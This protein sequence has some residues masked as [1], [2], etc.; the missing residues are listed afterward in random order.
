MRQG[1]LWLL[2]S[3]AFLLVSGCVG[4]K[5]VSTATLLDEMTDLREMAEFPSPAYTCR[6]FS[7]YD[8]ASESPEQAD[9][10]FANRDAGQF[11]RT[12]QHDGRDEYVMMDADGPGA[13]VRIW[14]ANPKGTLRVYLD[15]SETPVLEEPMADLLDG[16]VAGV[17][18]PIAGE[19]SRGHNC[20]LP[21]PYAKHCK[22]TC[23][24]EAFYYHI[25]Y[26]TYPRWTKLTSFKREDLT[27]L[28]P[29]IEQIAE[30][31]AAPR[32]SDVEPIPWIADRSV[33]A[34]EFVWPAELNGGPG[35][36]IGL[37]AKVDGSDVTQALRDVVLIIESDGER[38]VVCPLGDFCGAAPGVNA[39]ASLPLGV[40]PEGE[41][42]S[43]WVMP[44][45]KSARVGLHNLGSQT[46]HVKLG[47]ATSEY[48]WTRRSMHFHTQWWVARDVSTR[49][50]QDWNYVQ[51]AGK[52]VFAGAAFA[53]TNPVKTWWGE[54]DEKIYVDGE[55]FPSHFG[56][57]T[58]DYYGYAWCYNVPFTHA[59]HAQ[60]RCDGP[61]NYGHTAVNRWHIIDRIPFKR[62]FRFDMELWHW[63]ECRLPAMSVVTY[64]YARP[65]ASSNR[66][67]IDPADLP[68]PVV[69]PY[70]APR[71]DG[72][73][74]GEELRIVAKTGNPRPA[75]HRRV[76]QRAT[77]VV[78]RRAARRQARAGV[79]GT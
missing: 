43:H 77:S 45:R 11:L 38:T 46:T 25:N 24:E 18:V 48:E 49:P 39:Y 72:A 5:P 44:F 59:Y 26:R 19:R 76:Q 33:K 54:G 14:S 65:G 16:N 32:E 70:V 62:D 55:T 41:M 53:I 34:G 27:E 17:P 40:T 12:E 21:I 73:L 74:E 61:G 10:W 58:E 36:I 67:A 37:R 28:A 35:A 29:Q 13:I 30:R 20:F 3:I 23:D 50:M 42:W 6:Q 1:S 31:L 71:V 66:A 56:T 64:W 4:G 75:G 7:S 8:R 79:S 69:P 47:V 15:H 9:T 57:G 68:V 78:A 63:R 51:I 2:L 22:V 52:G 60:P